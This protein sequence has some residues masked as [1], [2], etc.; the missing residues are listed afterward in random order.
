MAVSSSVCLSAD[1]AEVFS[2]TFTSSIVAAVMFSTIISS[3]V[4]YLA[5]YFFCIKGDHCKSLN[6]VSGHTEQEP[7][8]QVVVYEEVGITDQP[9]KYA[10][11]SINTTSNL[12]Y[13][14]I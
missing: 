11:E 3:L 13:G 1:K 4:T 14:K 7:S 12:A 8:Q 10:T 2:V 5:T 6:E 9:H